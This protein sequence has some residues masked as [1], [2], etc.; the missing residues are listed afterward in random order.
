MDPAPLALL[1]LLCVAP[2]Q[3]ADWAPIESSTYAQRNAA[4]PRALPAT[5][6]LLTLPYGEFAAGWPPR[7][8][9][10]GEA[11]AE[12]PEPWRVV[13]CARARRRCCVA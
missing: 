8:V 11:Y 5:E 13:G 2:P 6:P 9:A 3:V 10:A 12:S 1:A 4:D 7:F